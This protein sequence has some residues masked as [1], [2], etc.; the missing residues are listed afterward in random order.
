MLYYGPAYCH[1][2]E[3]NSL[4]SENLDKYEQFISVIDP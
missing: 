2:D 1:G 4:M 3:T